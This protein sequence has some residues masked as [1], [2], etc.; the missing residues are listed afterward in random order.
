MRSGPALGGVNLRISNDFSQTRGRARLSARP[1]VQCVPVMTRS[2][3]RIK[4]EGTQKERSQKRIVLAL[5]VCTTAGFWP[6]AVPA[7]AEGYPDGVTAAFRSKT[8]RLLALPRPWRTHAPHFWARQPQWPPIPSWFV[9]SHKGACSPPLR[10][11]LQTFPRREH[12]R[13]DT[14]AMASR[15][16]WYL[17]P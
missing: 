17:Q 12:M 6:F 8:R 2:L 1:S 5:E 13:N 10:L 9:H 7:D 14:A 16:G 11:A 15:Y 3:G 4:P